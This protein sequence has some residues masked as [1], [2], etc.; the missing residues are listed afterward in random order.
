[1]TRRQDDYGEDWLRNQVG[2]VERSLSR[3]FGGHLSSERIAD[4]VA[5]AT[6]RFRDAA[7]R[8]FLPVLID[9]AARTQLRTELHHRQV[10]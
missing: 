6:D 3:D 5:T 8:P 10:A 1:M 9:R 4:A 2:L 7:V